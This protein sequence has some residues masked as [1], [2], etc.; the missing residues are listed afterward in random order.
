VAIEQGQLLAVMRWLDPAM[1]PRIAT[2][3]G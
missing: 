2:G 1:H 3:I